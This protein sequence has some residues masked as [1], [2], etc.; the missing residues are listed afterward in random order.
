MDAR[1]PIYSTR[2]VVVFAV[3][4]LAL[5]LAGLVAVVV[6]A[7]DGWQ[8]TA[9]VLGG[10]VVPWSVAVLWLSWRHPVRALGPLVMAGDLLTLLAVE[11]VTPDASRGVRSAAMFL[12]AAHAHFQGERRGVVLAVIWVVVL[13]GGSEIRGGSSLD[14]HVIAFHDTL[15]ALATVATGL[16]V[17]R[18]RTSETES[19]LRAHDL[20]RHTMRGDADTRRE[21]AR[22]IH[23]GPVQ[24]LIGL[25]MVL[26][27]LGRELE[28]DGAG[29]RSAELLAD[30]RDLTARN[31]RALREEMVNLGPYGFEEVTLASAIDDHVPAWRRRYEVEVEAEVEPGLLPEQTA[32]EL[33]RIA[34]EAVVNAG[35]HA[36]AR[37]VRVTTRRANGAIELRVEDDGRGFAAE[38][39]RP[40]H[41]G[42]ASMRERAELLGGELAIE[43]SERGTVVVAR[44]PLG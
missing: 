32:G 15:F 22:A 19:R 27:T 44:V 26:S 8:S 39:P 31:V 35:R 16:V 33:F 42:L 18:L 37:T 13:V 2:P 7:Y 9:A 29:A 25:D 43:S 5:S 12:I 10:L 23:D 41:L 6:L 28:R 17:G 1:L 4:R 24:D 11:L 14:W 20:S 21:L 38:A 3:A 30:A 40:G 36:G 34:Q